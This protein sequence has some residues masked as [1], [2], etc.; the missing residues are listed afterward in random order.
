M[1]SDTQFSK[2]FSWKFDFLIWW[3]KLL[4]HRW[5]FGRFGSLDWCL[6]KG[7][8]GARFGWFLYLLWS[9]HWRLWLSGLFSVRDLGFCSLLKRFGEGSQTSLVLWRGLDCIFGGEYSFCV[10]ARSFFWDHMA[11]WWLR[12]WFYLHCHAKLEDDFFTFGWCL[13]NSIVRTAVGLIE[14]YNYFIPV[15][16]AQVSST[17][18][19]SFHS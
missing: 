1:S 9:T 13:E 11:R 6:L 14:H 12:N 3:W 7:R 19:K 2:G 16:V 18:A 8:F 10:F 15:P 4:A 5:F 17:M